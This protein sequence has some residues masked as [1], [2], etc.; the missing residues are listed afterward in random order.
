MYCK[1]ASNIRN[2][3]EGGREEGRDNTV[4]RLRWVH[5]CNVTTYHNAVTLQV[6]DTIRS[7]GLNFHPVPHGVTVSC[8]HYTRGSQFV[9]GARSI[10]NIQEARGADGGDV[11]C[12]MFRPVQA[13]TVSSLWCD[14]QI[15]TAHQTCPKRYCVNNFWYVTWSWVPPTLSQYSVTVCGNVTSVYPPLLCQSQ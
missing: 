6:T 15:P 4:Y 14:S 11:S 7:Y 5:T 13:T 3:P 12:Y 8:E 9:M 10:M 2:L 1:T